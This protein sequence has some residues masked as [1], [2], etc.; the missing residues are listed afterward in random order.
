MKLKLF[1]LGLVVL[2]VMSGC[3]NINENIDIS[4]S[5]DNIVDISIRNGEYSSN[6]L[7]IE[8]G[9]TVRWIN[10]DSQGHTV[11]VENYFDSKSIGK[12]KSFSYTFKETGEFEYFCKIHEDFKGSIIVR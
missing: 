8:K 4:I 1:S 12:D 9:T 11:T 7:V 5:D 3:Q 6:D 2:S 10:Y